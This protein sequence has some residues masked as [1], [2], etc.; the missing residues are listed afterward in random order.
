MWMILVSVCW[1][2]QA[3]SKS[4]SVHNG[5][6]YYQW[7]T[8]ATDEVIHYSFSLGTFQIMPTCALLLLV[9]YIPNQLYLSTFPL[10]H[11]VSVGIVYN[12]NIIW[13]T[14][15]NFYTLNILKNTH[16][17][18]EI[19]TIIFFAICVYVKQ[20]RI[21]ITWTTYVAL[22]KYMSLENPPH[23]HWC[24]PQTLDLLT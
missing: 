11:V 20:K 7:W 17:S 5:S 15:C 4:Q 14:C 24:L 16:D 3:W 8:C 19:G 13:D 6:R 21:N 1:A 2:N 9:I 18:F 22:T 10:L 23:P 12:E